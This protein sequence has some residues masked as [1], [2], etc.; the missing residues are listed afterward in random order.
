VRARTEQKLKR[1]KTL[2]I[3]CSYFAENLRLSESKAWLTTSPLFTL[4][5]YSF[6]RFTDLG[7]SMLLLSAVA[8]VIVSYYPS[9]S[10][11]ILLTRLKFA[12]Y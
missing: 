11:E 4:L 6:Y 12:N 5:S 2:E 10:I 9:R 3:R 7:H 8:F 1:L